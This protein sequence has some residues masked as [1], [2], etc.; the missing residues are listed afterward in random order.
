LISVPALF[1][2]YNRILASLVKGRGTAKR[3]RDSFSVY[4]SII[5]QRDFFKKES[6][7]F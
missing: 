6:P 7:R 1:I 2:I 4:G 5:K 3:W